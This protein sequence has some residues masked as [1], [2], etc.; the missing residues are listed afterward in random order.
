MTRTKSININGKEYLLCYSTRVVRAVNDRFGNPGKMNYAL[1]ESKSAEE[2]IETMLLMLHELMKAGARFAKMEGTENPEP[3]S[4]KELHTIF[5][6][7]RPNT[8]TRAIRDAITFGSAVSV[9]V[10]TV[11]PKGKGRGKTQTQKKLKPTT[12]RYIWYGLHIGLDY[13]TTL[14]IPHGELLSL[15]NEE[16]LQSG[17]AEEK[18]LNSE[19]DPF[20][21]WE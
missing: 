18:I 19:E 8:V 14:D 15:I 6:L 21:D 12:D 5:P 2:R 17:A 11:E 13:N 4:I 1:M 7:L 16:M 3:L 9:E 10:K 20:P